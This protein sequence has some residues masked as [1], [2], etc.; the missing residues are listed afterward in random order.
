MKKLFILTLLICLLTG[1]VATS[2]SNDTTIV[3]SDNGI[4]TSLKD[5]IVI[6]DSSLIINKEGTYTV[7]G[8]STNGN[9]TINA[10]NVT[11]VLDNINL[12]SK[13]SAPI[14]CSKNSEVTIEILNANTL[15][16]SIN[17]N[18]ENGNTDAENAVIKGKDGSNITIKGSGTLNINAN[19]KNGI[20][21]NGEKSSLTIEKL[22]MNITALV[23]DAI[24][25]EGTLNLI[26]GIL[27]IDA[28]D[29]ALHCDNTLNIGDENN[30][31]TIT[32]NSCNEG[33]EGAT[34]NIN[35]GDIM[36]NSTDDCINAANSDL[37]NYNFEINI[38]GG[39]ITAYTSEGD[40]FDSNGDLNIN[41]GTISVWTANRAD[42][43]PLDADGSINI[44]GGTILAAG[45]SNG[46][47]VN[48]N[49][50]QASLIINNAN[51]QQD[52][53]LSINTSNNTT[54]YKTTATCNVS[55]IFF[56]SSDL[57]TDEEY[58][59]SGSQTSITARSGNIQTGMTNNF[60]G[61]Q[62]GNMNQPPQDNNMAPPQDG[63]TRPN[64]SGQQGPM[65]NQNQSKS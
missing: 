37:T 21:V 35:S 39:T 53:T 61:P 27:T 1:C 4:S 28:G 2:T 32:V 38:N 45:A 9:I 46:M 58:I 15:S 56:S 55:Y 51:V 29:D 64:E 6:N 18:D 60:G 42:N 20:K 17:N 48:I 12:T 3:F 44:N 19:G 26:S 10:T 63:M 14:I 11:L 33:I 16:D 23:N 25:V 52:D 57:N 59:V 54:I 24:N 30:S 34:V 36:I 43:E 7:T 22:T 41:D 47:G 50:S 13:N 5:G 8:S 40:G 62:Q 49:A 65:N 31:P